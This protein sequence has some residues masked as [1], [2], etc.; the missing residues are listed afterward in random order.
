MHAPDRAYFQQQRELSEGL[1][2]GI[3]D[4]VT[5][6]PWVPLLEAGAEKI[7]AGQSAGRLSRFP[8]LKSAILQEGLAH[9]VDADQ[10]MAHILSMPCVT[11]LQRQRPELS[12]PGV[13]ASIVAAVPKELIEQFIQPLWLM[14]GP[15]ANCLDPDFPLVESDGDKEKRRRAVMDVE[16]LKSAQD[17]FLAMQAALGIPADA[18]APA[19]GP[20]EV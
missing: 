14:D 6:K 17:T 7:F 15:L 18:Q 3:I 5:R 9:A 20:S 19:A 10:V 13:I 12:K 8:N 1:L 16:D 11:Q 4:F 2:R